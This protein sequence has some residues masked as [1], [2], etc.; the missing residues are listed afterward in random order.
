MYLEKGRE[1]EK[2]GERQ[3][4]ATA[5]G[6]MKRGK[7]TERGRESENEIAKAAS[8]PDRVDTRGDDDE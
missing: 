2:E 7:D 8:E 5:S 3:K 4:R 6:G 1:K